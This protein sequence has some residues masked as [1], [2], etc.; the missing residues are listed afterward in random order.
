ME[1]GEQVY[2]FAQRCSTVFPF[3][4]VCAI[5]HG[6]KRRKE[7]GLDTSRCRLETDIF[8]SAECVTGN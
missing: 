8:Y 5:T 3:V 2:R 7:I 6:E 4:R 1:E